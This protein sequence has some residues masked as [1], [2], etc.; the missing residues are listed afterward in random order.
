[1]TEQATIR[2]L[3]VDDHPLLREGITAIINSQP[4]MVMVAQAAT[5]MEGIEQ[6]RLHLPDFVL[7]EAVV[8]SLRAY[9]ECSARMLENLAD[10]V[11]GRKSPRTPGS[12]DS[13]AL[14]EQT[15]ELCQLNEPGL[16]LSEHG[17]SFVPLLRQIDRLTARLAGEIELELGGPE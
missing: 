5:G 4:D 1:M 2:V 14:L 7:P 8:V 6:Y 16:L 11:E 17:A 15:R 10:R 12:A 3:S 13:L 9:D